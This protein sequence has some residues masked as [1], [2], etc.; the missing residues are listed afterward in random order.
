[1]AKYK[2]YQWKVPRPPGHLK[3]GLIA[4]NAALSYPDKEVIDATTGEHRTYKEVN[5][6]SNIIANSLLKSYE[7]G[8]FI[9]VIT[10]MGID[11]TEIYFAAAKA[12]LIVIPMSVRLAPKE[13]ETILKYAGAKALIFDSRF[14]S[15]VAQVSFE[16]E[17]YVLGELIPGCLSYDELLN[18]DAKEPDIEITDDTLV[19][20]GFTSGTTGTPKSYLRTQYAN[21]LNHITYAISF[22]FTYEDIVLNLVPPLTGLSCG[23]AVILARGTIINQDFD[24]VGILKTIEKYK[25]TFLYGVPAMFS[26]IMNVPDLKNYD[27]SSLRAVGSVGAVLP[28]PILEQIWEKIT[29]NVYDH[30]GLQETGFIAVSK[31]DMKRAY[32]D[33][34]GPPTCLQEVRIVDEQ[35]KEKATGEIGEVIIRFPDGAGEYWKNDAKTNEAFRNGWFHTGD[36]GKYDQSGNLA[37]VGRLKDMLI[38]GGY[39]IFSVDVEEVILKYPKVVDCAVIGLPDNTWGEKVAAVI[40]LKPGENCTEEEIINYCKEKMAHYKAP[41][42]V[43]FDD[44]IRTLTGK[45]MKFA[46]V[47]KYRGK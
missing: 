12:G 35:D 24:P 36:L 37:I 31:P 10:R 42:A 28:R 13:I 2:G 39:N 30:L 11:I 44:V 25:V 4:K 38:S 45:A 41:K 5:E 1:M 15:M 43:F 7:P 33:F 34:V 29:P 6:R 27:L 20:L 26:F 3:I 16:Q 21:F 9:G 23:C 8:D 22:D 46:M 32:P 47:E 19:T 40:R 14:K 18:G 17:K